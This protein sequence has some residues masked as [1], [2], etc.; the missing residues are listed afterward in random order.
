[1]CFNL[2]RSTLQTVNVAIA[3]LFCMVAGFD[4]LHVVL[5]W[6]NH[7]NGLRF[8]NRTRSFC[9][10]SSCWL[11]LF[12]CCEYNSDLVFSSPLP[13][14]VFSKFIMVAQFQTRQFVGEAAKLESMGY[15]LVNVSTE[16]TSSHSTTEDATTAL[17]NPNT[18]KG[19]R[20]SIW[21]DCHINKSNRFWFLAANLFTAF[22]YLCGMNMSMVA[23][24]HSV[25]IFK[26][27]RINVLMPYKCIGVFED[28]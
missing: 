1:M 9:V 25:V 18:L 13:S 27:D 21:L 4:A 23:G 14:K 24:C 26:V 17:I 19:H 12:L 8:E 15:F 10:E 2:C 3:T 6:E 22:A 5:F 28:A 7:S 11:D 20:R 16:Q